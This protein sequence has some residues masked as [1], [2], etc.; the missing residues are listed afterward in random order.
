MPR[1]FEEFLQL[2][3]VKKV[4]ADRPRAGFLIEESQ[5]SMIG[6]KKRVDAPGIDEYNANS[7]VK[8]CYDVMIE[9]I[10]AKLLLDGYSASGTHAHEAEVSYLKK[11]GFP[12]GEISAL[13]ELRHFRNSITYYGKILTVEY[14]K[15]VAGFTIRIYPQLKD[16]VK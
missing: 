8:D 5:K 15:Q 13:N 9:L 6:L 16:L 12:E 2:G 1:A 14:A 11:L 10:R 7:V 4:S 3:T